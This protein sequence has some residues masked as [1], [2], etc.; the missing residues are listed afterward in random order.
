MLDIEIVTEPTATVFD[1]VS[2]DDLASHIRASPKLRQNAD[3]VARMTMALE[4]ACAGLHG[5]DGRLNRMIFETQ[6]KLW[7]R[8]WPR[9][10]YIELPY[11]NLISVDAFELSDGTT[12]TKGTDFYVTGSLVKRLEPVTYWPDVTD[13]KRAIGITYTAGYTAYPA[14]L[15]RLIMILAAHFLQAPE[16]AVNESKITAISKKVEFGVDYLEAQLK[17]PTAYVDWNE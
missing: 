1:I 8:K 16:A 7:L 17:V 14:N 11:P 6:L 13:G 3:Y 12:L 9:K 5:I 10:T 4:A 15:K 2:L